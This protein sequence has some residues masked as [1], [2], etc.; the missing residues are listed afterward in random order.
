MIL[1]VD[2][3]DGTIAGFVKAVRRGD[4]LRGMVVRLQVCEKR[5]STV[6]RGPLL[7]HCPTQAG[8]LT[9]AFSTCYVKYTRLGSNQ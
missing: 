8:I 5:Y 7:P 2:G 1:S 3:D 6:F 4:L 9:P